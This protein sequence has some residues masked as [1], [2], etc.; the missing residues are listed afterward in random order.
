MFKITSK[1]GFHIL[2]N[3][4]TLSVQF[5]GGN[6]CEN[7]NDTIETSK[8]EPLKKCHNAEMA[9]WITETG[10]WISKEYILE[11]TGSIDEDQD[12]VMPRQT[13]ADMHKMLEW[14]AARP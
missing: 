3:G 12:D 11:T 7:Y 13:V 5:G 10:E 6:Y 1:H 9:I 4:C 8:T 2:L 14:I